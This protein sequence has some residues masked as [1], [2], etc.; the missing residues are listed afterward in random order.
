VT[1][2]QL[3]VVMSAS[4]AIAGGFSSRSVAQ[5]RAT[6]SQ[7]AQSPALDE[8]QQNVIPVLSKNCLECHSDR[9]HTGNLSL[10]PFRDPNAL[11]TAFRRV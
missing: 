3:V 5:G 1:I 6:Q 7:A 2:T 9:L 4:A 10:E 8:F 11:G